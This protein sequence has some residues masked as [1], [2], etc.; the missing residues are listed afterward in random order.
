MKL[1][2]HRY[3]ISSFVYRARKP[4]HPKRLFNLIHD[5]FI[6]LQNVDQIVEEAEEDDGDSDEEMEDSDETAND[7]E[8][9]GSSDTEMEDDE[10]AEKQF[11]KEIPPE[12]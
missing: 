11:Q 12:V 1:T 10:L 3:G 7:D 4:F 5:K 9:L 2:R 6:T 8:P